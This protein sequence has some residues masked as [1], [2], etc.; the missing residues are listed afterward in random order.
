ML[1]ATGREKV[2]VGTR[3]SATCTTA[4]SKHVSSQD[5]LGMLQQVSQSERGEQAGE[6]REKVSMTMKAKGSNGSYV[7]KGEVELRW[8][9]GRST[10]NLIGSIT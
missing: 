9:A 5:A 8:K 10:A 2:Q 4:S 6:T 3:E 7:A 1:Y